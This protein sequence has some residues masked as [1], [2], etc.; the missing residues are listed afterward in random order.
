MMSSVF[1][2]TLSRK[3]ARVVHSSFPL[4]CLLL[5]ASP[6]PVAYGQSG[7]VTSRLLAATDTSSLESIYQRPWYVKVQV[8]VPEKNSRPDSVGTIERWQDGEKSKTVYVLG[9]SKLTLLH[10][11]DKHY[12]IQEGDLIPDAVKDGFEDILHPGPSAKAL[13][14]TQPEMRKQPFGNVTLDCVVLM[15][16]L[17]KNVVAP[18][19][20]FRATASQ[21]R[22]RLPPVTTSAAVPF[23]RAARQSFLITMWSWA[24]SSSAVLP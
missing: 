19:G 8:D 13:E 6:S 24:M 21:P 3:A 14:D 5:A 23:W 11:E 2:T 17:P 18:M 15:R 22:T 16:T 10:T 9:S 1:C 4:V 12:R 20:L 7:S